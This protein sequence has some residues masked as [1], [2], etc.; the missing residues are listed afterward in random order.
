MVVRFVFLLPAY[1]LEFENL[2]RVALQ[3]MYQTLYNHLEKPMDSFRERKFLW[4]QADYLELTVLQLPK[5]FYIRE[6][7]SPFERV[8]RGNKG[9]GDFEYYQ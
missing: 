6:R 4:G 3:P 8:Q 1:V 9:R 7:R 5:Y 2:V